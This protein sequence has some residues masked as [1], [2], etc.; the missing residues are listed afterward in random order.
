[1]YIPNDDTEFLNY[2]YWLKRLDTQLNKTN[3]QNAIKSPTDKETFIIKL[4]GLL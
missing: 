3:N 4:C 2:N 1:M